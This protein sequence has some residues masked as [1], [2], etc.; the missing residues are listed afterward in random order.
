MKSLQ[1]FRK[2]RR[3][4]ETLKNE[5]FR[6]NFDFEG[7]PY[8]LTI[9]KMKLNWNFESNFGEY[10]ARCS[11]KDYWRRDS[12]PLVPQHLK[13]SSS[14]HCTRAE[15]HVPLE[16]KCKCHIPSPTPGFIK[17]SGIEDFKSFG[18]SNEN[19]LCC[20]HMAPAPK[21]GNNEKTTIFRPPSVV[22]WLQKQ[23]NFR[24]NSKWCCGTR[25]PEFLS[26]VLPSIVF[27][28]RIILASKKPRYSLWLTVLRYSLEVCL[29]VCRSPKWT[30]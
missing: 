21:Q 18:N 25:G 17:I 19:S 9:Y 16:L 30:F 12:Y 10:H 29:S 1:I 8:T 20:L 6:Y 14:S 15:H 22:R 7:V 28:K 2:S 3:G 23:E 24:L 26:W 27:L 13:S 5:V 11:L 4:A